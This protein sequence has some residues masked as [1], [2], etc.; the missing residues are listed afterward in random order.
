MSDAREMVQYFKGNPGLQRLVNKFI[1]KYQSLGRIGGSVQLNKLTPAEQQAL[2]DLLGKDYSKQKSATISY[3]QLQKVLVCTKFHA[4]DWLEFLE[5]Y[6]GTELYSNQEQKATLE[7]NRQ[8]FFQQMLA[9]YD[10]PRCKTWLTA[11]AEKKA[12]HRTIYTMYE[13]DEAKLDTLIKQV[14]EALRQLPEAQAYVRLPVFAQKVTQN[15]HGFDLQSEAGRMLISA[16]QFL[17]ISS[18]A[19]IENN[20]ANVATLYSAEYATEIL[21]QFGIVRDDILNFVTVSGLMA[22][23]AGQPLAMWRAALRDRAVLNLP[24]RELVKIDEFSVGEQVV[25]I[26]EN[27][28]VFSALL[29][30]DFPKQQPA[31][32]CTHGQFRLAALQLLDRLV[33]SGALLYYSGDHDPEGLQMAQKLAN[34]YPDNL[35]LWRFTNSDYQGINIGA[36]LTEQRLQKL[37]NIRHPQLQELAAAIAASGK[38][39]YQEE[40]I[41][42]LYQDILD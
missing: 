42:A 15:P 8:A 16:L 18:A 36:K 28:G 29:D 33:S 21:Q 24:L 41:E 6:A 11:L 1:G 20:Q 3:V 22:Y 27:S 25:Y 35:T 4:V 13:E 5:N 26:V 7:S 17:A 14:L 34:R 40:L 37:Q 2:T 10:H 19:N 30:K 9:R 39:G 12:S 32:I 38:P 23:R 31:L